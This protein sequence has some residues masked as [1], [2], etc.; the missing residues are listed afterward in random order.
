MPLSPLV[1]RDFYDLKSEPHSLRNCTRL[2]LPMIKIGKIS[3]LGCRE[4]EQC[5]VKE[6]S[7]SGIPRVNVSS[8]TFT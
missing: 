8:T 4:R 6:L 2:Q 1:I 3:S 5:A 7:N